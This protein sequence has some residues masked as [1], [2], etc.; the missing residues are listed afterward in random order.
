MRS[1]TTARN[2]VWAR[3]LGRAA[4]RHVSPARP[5]DAPVSVGAGRAASQE[6]EP[7]KS[8]SRRVTT[9][10]RIAPVSPDSRGLA[11]FVDSL[12][13]QSLQQ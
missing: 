4:T 6:A 10:T 2:L 3:G 8:I 7:P 12:V 11:A 5:V 13:E 1:N 9:A